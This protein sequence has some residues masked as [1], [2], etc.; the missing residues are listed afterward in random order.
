MLRLRLSLFLLGFFALQESMAAVGLDQEACGE[1]EVEAVEMAEAEALKT[2][3][4]QVKVSSSATFEE[5]QVAFLQS[6]QASVVI[7]DMAEFQTML[8]Q[9]DLELTP[10]ADAVV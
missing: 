1:E 10:T 5:D 3:L 6:D 7:D 8:V 4:L 9:T 2:E